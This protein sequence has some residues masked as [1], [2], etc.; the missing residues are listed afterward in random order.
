MFNNTLP[1]HRVTQLGLSGC[2]PAC[3]AVINAA[4]YTAKQNTPRAG[5]A[6][7]LSGFR[8]MNGQAA[9][10]A[11]SEAPVRSPF[12]CSG[13]A[14]T[15]VALQQQLVLSTVPT[16][17]SLVLHRVAGRLLTA[18]LPQPATAQRLTRHPDSSHCLWGRLGTGVSQ[19]GTNGRIKRDDAGRAL[20]KAF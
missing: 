15:L 7:G 5:E 1:H 6:G 9:L 3:R 18:D 10:P 4:F 13:C 20:G 8:S 17:P 2:L 19:R 11:P 16:P 12:Q 14:R